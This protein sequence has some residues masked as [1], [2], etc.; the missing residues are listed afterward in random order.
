MKRSLYI[1]CTT[2][3][4]VLLAAIAHACIEIWYTNLLVADFSTY[5]LGFSWNQWHTM[6][7]ILEVIF[8]ILGAF[9]GQ[10]LGPQWWRIVYIERRHWYR[11]RR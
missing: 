7:S 11:K 4:G 2:V 9:L 8:F 6:Y 5:S 3:L 10:W 1:I